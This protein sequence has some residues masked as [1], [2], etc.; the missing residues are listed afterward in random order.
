MLTKATNFYSFVKLFKCVAS[1][2]ES[3]PFRFRKQTSI[4]HLFL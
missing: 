3:R 4:D 2:L 1:K